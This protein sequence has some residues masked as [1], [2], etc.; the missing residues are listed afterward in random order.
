MDSWQ[1][2]EAGSADETLTELWLA[3]HSLGLGFG[4]CC[5]AHQP[6]IKKLFFSFLQIINLHQKHEPVCFIL[7]LT[8]PIR[9]LLLNTFLKP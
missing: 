4:E 1:V 3:K 8:K 5:F 6:P 2:E 9:Q 7:G